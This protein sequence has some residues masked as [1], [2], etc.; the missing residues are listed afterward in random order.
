MHPSLCEKALPRF[1]L[2]ADLPACPR[3]RLRVQVCDNCFQPGKK[4]SF[5]AR[6]LPRPRRLPTLFVMR[7][8]LDSRAC[9]PFLTRARRPTGVQGTWRLG[10]RWSRPA[11]R[12]VRPLTPSGSV[13]TSTRCATYA[14]RWGIS[15]SS[16]AWLRAAGA[17]S[18]EA[19]RAGSRRRPSR[20][21]RPGSRPAS[22]AAAAVPRCVCA[23]AA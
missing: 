21:F 1:A 18:R 15:S 10:V 20:A 5:F 22:G 4:R 19:F 7:S 8:P 6:P 23:R 11:T 13:P 17:D 14:A 16:A 3:H 9:G 2:A 12:A